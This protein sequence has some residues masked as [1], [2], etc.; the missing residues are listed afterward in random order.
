MLQ[1]QPKHCIRHLPSDLYHTPDISATQVSAFDVESSGFIYLLLVD[2]CLKVLRTFIRYMLPALVTW[3]GQQEAL[4]AFCNVEEEL[5]A[6]EEKTGLQQVD[7][8]IQCTKSKATFRI[9]KHMH[10]E[11][12]LKNRFLCAKQMSQ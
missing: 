6:D 10:C 4:K 3:L 1:L 12:R 9:N 2:R 11:Y 8:V 7:P 5:V